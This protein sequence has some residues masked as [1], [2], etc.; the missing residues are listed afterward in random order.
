MTNMLLTWPRAWRTGFPAMTR[1]LSRT[2]LEVHEWALPTS[3]IS[4]WCSMWPTSIGNWPAS[5][6]STE[7]AEWL[8]STIETA[9][10]AAAPPGGRSRDLTADVVVVVLVAGREVISCELEIGS[11]S[12][13]LVDV[14]CERDVRTAHKR[15]ASL[16]HVYNTQSLL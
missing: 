7:L 9:A 8:S 2:S 12:V 4:V 15:R 16:T 6:P 10:A 1:S 14:S 3:S 5:A 11:T 13:S